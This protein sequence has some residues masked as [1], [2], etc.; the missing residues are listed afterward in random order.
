MDRPDGVPTR[1]HLA[2][3]LLG[4]M[5]IAEQT[6]TWTVWAILLLALGCL[7][8]RSGRRRLTTHAARRRLASTP[9]P[10]KELAA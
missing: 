6:L 8:V 7:I 2:S 1:G 3:E 10:Y 9:A 5:S 4:V